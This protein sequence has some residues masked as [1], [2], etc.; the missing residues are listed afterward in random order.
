MLKISV[1]LREKHS[2][3]GVGDFEVVESGKVKFGLVFH[4][5]LDIGEGECRHV[6]HVPVGVRPD[7]GLRP[8]FLQRREP[9]RG[10]GTK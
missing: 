3:L 4:E 8:P 5:M 7:R 10:R 9:S 1:Y 2:E 6:N